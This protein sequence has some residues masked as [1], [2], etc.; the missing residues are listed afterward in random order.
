MQ[1]KKIITVISS[2]VLVSA[3]PISLETIDSTSVTESPVNEVPDTAVNTGDL[4]SPVESLEEQLSKLSENQKKIA[5]EKYY[6]I[7]KDKKPTVVEE[8]DRSVPIDN[9][10]YS[11]IVVDEDAI[12]NGFSGAREVP[13]DSTIVE[14]KD[15]PVPVFG[16]DYSKG[17]RE[18][19][20]DSNNYNIIDKDKIIDAST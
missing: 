20:K 11:K 3:L 17:A 8:K 14:E 12:K 7:V 2:L 4:Y 9:T 5:I 10:D 16:T 18:V 1:I 15:H 19:P 6:G 13:K